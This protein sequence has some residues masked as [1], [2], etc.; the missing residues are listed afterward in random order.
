MYT[1]MYLPNDNPCLTA[2]SFLTPEEAWD[3]IYSV[4]CQDCR[5]EYER[6]LTGNY[7]KED[8]EDWPFYPC[9]AEWCVLTTA[10]Y[11]EL[12]DE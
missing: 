6:Y 5:N 4:M 10:E 8:E 7:N 11:N 12:G 3:Y 9:E 1:A 2:H